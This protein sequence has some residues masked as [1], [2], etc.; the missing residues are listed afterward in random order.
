MGTFHYDDLSPREQR[1]DSVLI[2]DDAALN[3]QLYATALRG[4]FNVLTAESGIEALRIVAETPPQLILLDVMMPE[5][6]GF[7]TAKLLQAHPRSRNIPIIFLTALDDKDSQLQGLAVGAVDFLS[8]PVDLGILRLRVNNQLERERLRT[9]A[10]NYQARLQDALIR[11]TATRNMLEAIFNASSD[12]LLVV[13]AQH[14]IVNA[15]CHWITCANATEQTLIGQPLTCLTF[16]DPRQQVIAPPQLLGCPH[17]LECELNLPGGEIRQIQVRSQAFLAHGNEA[18]HL[19]TLRDISK[20]LA[21]EAREKEATERLNELIFEL[22]QQKYALDAHS[23]VSIT[24]RHGVITYV[25]RKLC[26][27]SGYS[28]EE[29]I[30][31]THRVLKSGHHDQAF[32]ADMW[33]AIR[34]GRTW[35]GEIANRTK[36]GEICWFLSTIVPW[37]DETGRPFQYVAIRT[38][39]TDRHRAE[40][41]LAAARQRELEIGAQIQ[42]RLLLGSPPGKLEGVSLACYSEG[43]Q[44]V[45]GDFYIFTRLDNSTFQVLTGDVMGKGI[46]A[47]L[48]A[49]GITSGYEKTLV[50][51][52]ATRNR[53]EFPSLAA[54]MNSLHDKLT[55]EL[56]ELGA[57]VT[58]SLIR[59]DR[60][61]LSMSWVNAGH[62]PIL[63][64][65]A[66]SGKIERLLSENL[67]FGVLPEECYV[68]YQTPLEIGDSL[69]IYSDGLSE[70]VNQKGEQYGEARIT[71][72]LE[73]GN[74]RRTSPSI[75]LNS[76][77]SDIHRHTAYSL[78]GDD[79]TAIVVQFRPLRDPS[80]RGSIKDRRAPEYLDLKRDLDQ[81]KPLRQRIAALCADQPEEYTQALTLAA[82]ESATNIIRHTPQIKGTPPITAILERNAEEAAVELVYEGTPFNPATPPDPD[83]SGN[84]F[85]GF[86]RYIIAHSIDRTIYDA[87]MPGMAS[88]RLVKKFPHHR[89]PAVNPCND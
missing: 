10:L 5:M 27:L 44:G 89:T 33:S 56:I 60:Q 20:R 75:I 54:I 19:L 69:V 77:R 88:I 45:D 58:M 51:L 38:D 22:G 7:Q 14:L 12:A 42:N 21:H 37:L 30:G 79:S 40:Q 2:V 46:T 49:S 4:Q 8:K 78:G 29:L 52:L 67:P 53:G 43:S 80:R 57:F 64:A 15:N 68:E 86:G 82:F 83:F 61:K 62:T 32:Y 9:T 3:R 11:Q 65:R 66:A 25:N 31:K 13:D 48:I 36:S 34:S 39:I 70:S 16:R 85:G 35:Q 59:F 47:A 55:L 28:S 17:D 87:P 50:E 23:L 72:I 73:T 24:D 81:L 84:S 6:D 63:L 74:R 76:L 26:E 71:H 1:L 41:A 18:F